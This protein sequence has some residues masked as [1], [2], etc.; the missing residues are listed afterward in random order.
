VQGQGQLPFMDD[1]GDQKMD[2][3]D[4]PWP[5]NVLCPCRLRRTVSTAYLA[6]C[7]CR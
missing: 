4:G 2:S 3:L 6:Q 7:G 1:N 5:L